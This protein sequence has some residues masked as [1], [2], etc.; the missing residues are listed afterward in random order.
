MA[1]ARYSQLSISKHHVASLQ[2]Q[3]NEVLFGILISNEL[4]LKNENGSHSKKGI[5]CVE[6]YREVL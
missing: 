5:E 6:V 4:E 2:F 1:S 3:E